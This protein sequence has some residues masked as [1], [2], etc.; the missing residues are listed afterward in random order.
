MGLI[1][2]A[3]KMQVWWDEMGHGLC[4]NR[5]VDQ[6]LPAFRAEFMGKLG[7]GIFLGITYQENYGVNQLLVD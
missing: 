5:Y 4:I 7:I 3:G 1:E 6:G 2:F